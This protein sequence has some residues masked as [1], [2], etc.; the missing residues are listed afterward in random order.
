MMIAL[1][2]EDYELLGDLRERGGRAAI[3][4]ARPREGAER[5]VKVGYATSRALNMSDIEYQI[6]QA[7]RKALIFRRYGLPDRLYRISA[8]THPQGGPSVKFEYAGDPVRFVDLHG[9]MNL[10]TELN[11]IGDVETA[12]AINASAETARNRSTVGR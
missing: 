7:G 12:S 4:H 5:L 10:A 9:A 11:E 2:A 8:A 3:S 1:T 6:T